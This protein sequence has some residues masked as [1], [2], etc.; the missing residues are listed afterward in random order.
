MF[1]S[2]IRRGS[3]YTFLIDT[4]TFI[5]MFHF[6]LLSEIKVSFRQMDLHQMY[7]EELLSISPYQ[8]LLCPVLNIKIFLSWNFFTVSSFMQMFQFQNTVL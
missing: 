2:V 8:T 5:C 1:L 4:N 7:Q 6:I 3:L